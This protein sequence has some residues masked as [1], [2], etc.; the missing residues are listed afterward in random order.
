MI[1]T[2]L[3]QFPRGVLQEAFGSIHNGL[4]WT[5]APQRIWHM[6]PPITAEQKRV[7]CSPVIRRVSPT[8]IRAQRYHWEIEF[9]ADD[10]KDEEDFRGHLEFTGTQEEAAVH[11]EQHHPDFLCRE[12]VLHRNGRAGG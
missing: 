5:D 6:N 11:A 2:I 3:Q 12:I 1:P 7:L 9:V 4:I 10:L 8:P